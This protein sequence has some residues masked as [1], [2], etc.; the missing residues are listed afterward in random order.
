MYAASDAIVFPSSWEGFGNPLV[1]SVVAG[2][3]IAVDTYPA[4]EELVGLGFR[5]LS[6]DDPE[7]LVAYLR[8]PDPEQLEANRAI[9]RRSFDLRDL[10]HRIADAFGTVGWNHW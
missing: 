2:R 1:E 6:V 3:P 9:A 7:A 5:F 4:L 10:P 8:A